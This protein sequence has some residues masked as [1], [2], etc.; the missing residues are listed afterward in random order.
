MAKS[1]HQEPPAVWQSVG[2]GTPAG[3][4]LFNLFS[5]NVNGKQTGDKYSARNKAVLE[6]KV[7][8]GWRPSLPGAT[9]S[10]GLPKKAAVCVPKFRKALSAGGSVAAPG[11]KK[12]AEVIWKE[13]AQRQLEVE[14]Q[15]MPPPQGPLLDDVEKQR[16]AEWMRYKD[17]FRGRREAATPARHGSLHLYT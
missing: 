10:H 4:A 16:L 11:G 14:Q 6:A 7:A 5:D 9:A 1:S 3:R 15:R 17:R 13:L 12:S 2:R 8:M